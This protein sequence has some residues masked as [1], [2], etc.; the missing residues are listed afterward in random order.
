MSTASHTTTEPY[1]LDRYDRQ[2][3]QMG[4]RAESPEQLRDWQQELR[5][6]LRILTGIVT[7][8]SCPLAPETGAQESFGLTLAIEPSRCL[9]P[10]R[11]GLRSGR[12][13]HD[14]QRPA[15]SSPTTMEMIQRLA[16][17]PVRER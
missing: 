6:R 8:Q 14:G 11:S 15:P 13:R 16:R 12:C 3:R 4:L 9:F 17:R 5:A 2:G 7:M 1:L 10:W